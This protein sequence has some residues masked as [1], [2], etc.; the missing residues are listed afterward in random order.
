M[1]VLKAGGDRNMSDQVEGVQVWRARILK[2]TTGSEGW[3]TH[4]Q[5]KTRCKEISQESTKKSL[6]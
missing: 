3:S 4:G 5:V 1:S 6:A 2:M